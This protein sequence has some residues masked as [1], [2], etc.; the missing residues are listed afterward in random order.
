MRIVFTRPLEIAKAMD[1]ASLTDVACAMMYDIIV[2]K[3]L[4][5]RP[6]T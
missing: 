3:N 2:L 4:R 5:F 6:S 1:L